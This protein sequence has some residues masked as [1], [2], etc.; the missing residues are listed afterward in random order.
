MTPDLSLRLFAPPML[1]AVTVS[2]PL[3]VLI[4][5]LVVGIFQVLTQTQEMSLIFIPKS[6]GAGAARGAG[7][8]E[9]PVPL[10]KAGKMMALPNSAG[11]VKP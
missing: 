1:K 5:G 7:P 8:S 10:G 11:A 9:A 4:V 2:V 6:A 3:T